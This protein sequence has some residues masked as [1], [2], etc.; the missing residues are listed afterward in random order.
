MRARQQAKLPSARVKSVKRDNAE[1]TITWPRQRIRGVPVTRDQLYAW[2]RAHA[3]DPAD[4]P[5]WHR[6]WAEVAADVAAHNRSR[7][8]REIDE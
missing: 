3:D 2:A 1:Y 8:T 7:L 4:H 5:L 6:A